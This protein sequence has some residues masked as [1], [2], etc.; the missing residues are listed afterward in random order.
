MARTVINETT[1]ARDAWGNAA[2]GGV[3]QTGD[4]TN[5]MYLADKGKSGTLILHVKN[6]NAAA[7]T[8]TIKAGVGGPTNN[9]GFRSGYGDL[10]QV[11]AL[12]SGE[13]II[14]V[15]DTTRF[16]QADGSINIDISGS[17]VTIAAYRLAGF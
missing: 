15:S 17:N 4:N 13:N 3:Y 7:R 5:G 6:T 10:A 12:T 8:V 11:V 1:L 9:I 2:A 14:L 16:K